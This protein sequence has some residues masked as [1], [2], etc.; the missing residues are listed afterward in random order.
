M[1]REGRGRYFDNILRGEEGEG[2]GGG[3][4][5]G[6]GRRGGPRIPC[7]SSPCQ[8]WQHVSLFTYFL[9][10]I[11]FRKG[12]GGPLARSFL[13]LSPNTIMTVVHYNIFLKNITSFEYVM[14]KTVYNNTYKESYIYSN[15]SMMSIS[16]ATW[17]GYWPWD[18]RWPPLWHG[19]WPWINDDHLYGKVTEPGMNVGHPHGKVTGPGMNDGHLYGKVTGPGMNDGHLYG[20]VTDPGMND[21]H[22][23]DTVT[24]PG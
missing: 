11:A 17:Q 1:Q 24:E 15:I 22:L 10:N 3:D 8:D 12:D 13:G 4:E 14:W 18:E 6:G 2:E 16:M 9:S 20:K 19:Y 21:G 5:G 7:L 23:Y